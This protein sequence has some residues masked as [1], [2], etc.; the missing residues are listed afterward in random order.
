[1]WDEL[2]EDHEI[3]QENIINGSLNPSPGGKETIL[4]VDTK[5]FLGG[6]PY[7]LAMR[8]YDEQNNAGGISNFGQILIQ[9]QCDINGK[10]KGHPVLSFSITND[11]IECLN[12]CKYGPYQSEC[13]WIT[14][15]LDTGLCELFENCNLSDAGDC[16]NCM[17]S[18]VHCD[19]STDPACYI[20]GLCQVQYLF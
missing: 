19:T 4:L 16:T 20:S 18:E 5:L 2:D 9:P 1:M 8:A 10:C 6:I 11:Q 12:Q 15:D 3:K 17:S 7:Y 13:H 14:F